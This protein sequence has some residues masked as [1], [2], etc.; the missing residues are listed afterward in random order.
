MYIQY[1]KWII[2]FGGMKKNESFILGGVKNGNFHVFQFFLKYSLF[3]VKM[4]L[5]SGSH[6]EQAQL[7]K[8]QSYMR[9]NFQTLYHKSRN[10]YE[11]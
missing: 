10:N 11:I 7:L 2:L 3:F 8:S 4:V 9:P 1:L 5:Y 6:Y